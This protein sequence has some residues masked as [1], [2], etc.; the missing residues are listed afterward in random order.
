MD[1]PLSTKELKMKKIKIIVESS[2]EDFEN[3][4]FEENFRLAVL[5][6]YENDPDV[7]GLQEKLSRIGFVF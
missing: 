3:L 2:D 4:D 6:G 1:F 5:S 7:K